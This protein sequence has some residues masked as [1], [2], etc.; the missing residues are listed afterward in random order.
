[1][2]E[3][4][5]Q[6]HGRTFPSARGERTRPAEA[7]G[8]VWLVGL[9]VGLVAAVLAFLFAPV[10]PPPIPTVEGAE[11]LADD[12]ATVL[13][14][15]D[16]QGLV[17]ARFPVDDPDA[18][19][20]ARA[21]TEG[22]TV[23]VDEETRFETGSL[24]KTVTAMTLAD[25]VDRGETSLDRTLFEIF[26]D[27]DFADPAVAGASLED[28]ATHHSGLPTV[29]DGMVL[30]AHVLPTLTLT[31]P[32]AAVPPPVEALETTTADEPGAFQYSNL[33]FSVLGAALAAESGTPYG[34]LVAERVLEPLGMDDTVIGVP[35][36][37]AR[38][39]SVPGAPTEPWH[40][41]AYAPA[42]SAT[43]ST[44]ADLTR[45]LT[46]V[47]R[48]TA[49]GASAVQPVYEWIPAPR[50]GSDHAA[51]GLAWFTVDVTGVGS[52]TRHAGD[53]FGTSTML[54][55]DDTQGVVVMAN[56]QSVDAMDLAYALLG[57]DP[58]PL[59]P[60][61]P[62][63]VTVA[64]T[65]MTVVAPVLLLSLMVRRRTLVTGSPLDRLRV[66][67]LSLG[68]VAWLVA[69][70]R[71]GDWTWAPLALWALAAGAVAAGVTVGV[72]HFRRAPTENGR[73]RWLHVPV[74]VLSV[75]FS[76]ALGSLTLWGLVA[77][78]A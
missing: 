78:A 42:G 34:E 21:G 56:S 25:M 14:A 24:F 38:P 57:D 75:I 62:T 29:P 3:P 16:V 27:V 12:V 1:M 23:P 51:I 19:A 10:A 37:G 11:A 40:N 60:A 13:D 72:W 64:V 9:A 8:R 59:P 26:P 30:R 36:G 66:V 71:L 5:G 20:F 43:W 58:E 76:L 47:A 33:G 39:H 63:P 17:V 52:V 31:D 74:F 7:P 77:A 18:V 55:F 48:G 49:P 44:P 61:P 32:F 65:A 53:T 2:G 73:W 69:G 22:G 41:T 46:A 35:G 67:S 50:N 54:A 4:A 45:L 70:Q 68:A 6:G 28:L 15:R